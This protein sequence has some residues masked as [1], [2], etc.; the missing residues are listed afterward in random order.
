MKIFINERILTSGEEWA[1]DN[2]EVLHQNIENLFKSLNC[3]RFYLE[4]NVLYSGI[5]LEALITNLTLLKEVG[6][7]TLYDPATQLRVLL[8]EINAVN[9]DDNKIQKNDHTY[10]YEPEVGAEPINVDGSSI[11]EAAEYFVNGVPVALLNLYSS[12]FNSTNPLY[13]RRGSRVS[14]DSRTDCKLDII[15][16]KEEVIAYI[17]MHQRARKYH[18]SEKHGENAVGVQYYHGK[19]ASPL[20]CNRNEAAELLPNAVGCRNTSELYVYDVQRAK[21]MVF[22]RENT[23]DNHF[24]SYHPINQNEVPESVRKFLRE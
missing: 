10:Y 11:A 4:P 14:P 17:K 5:G 15:I 24:H 20:E 13:V 3:L 21:F 9:W 7:Y 8:N 1:T 6:G 19:A 12:T 16:L 18:W 23:P 22:K 2:M